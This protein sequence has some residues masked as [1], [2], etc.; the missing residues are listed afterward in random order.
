[1]NATFIVNAITASV[2]MGLIYGIATV[3][4]S[5]GYRHIKFPDFTTIASIMVGGVTCVMVT[6]QTELWIFGL[7]SGIV[8][9]SLLGLCTGLQITRCN[10][11]PTLA[12]I[13]TGVGATTLAFV[14]THNQADVSLKP[15][16]SGV[17]LE[18]IAGNVF[19]WSGMAVGILELIFVAF[20]VSHIFSTR[21]G[22]YILALQGTKNYVEHR[23]HCVNATLNGLLV[24]S[25]A[26]IGLAGALAA[27]QNG[28]AA[29]ENHKEFLVLALA[30]YSLGEMIILEINKLSKGSFKKHGDRLFSDQGLPLLTPAYRW[31][32]DIVTKNDE[33]PIKILITLCTYG[34][35]TVFINAIFKLI[36]IEYADK[37]LNFIFKAGLLFLILWLGQYLKPVSRQ[38]SDE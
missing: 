6:N 10:I 28:Q 12:G 20:V 5:L 27:F 36:E 21:Y 24:L 19:S 16:I 3:G 2:L 29:V 22:D 35:A 23:H 4:F 1:M 26:I 31:F 13:T 9:G 11:P 33:E 37:N 15:G 18:F 7:L 30:G 17:F 32:V 34:C 14:I 38:E 25:N 8:V